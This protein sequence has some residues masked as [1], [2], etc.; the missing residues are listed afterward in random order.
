VCGA[1][2]LFRRQ[3]HLPQ[4]PGITQLQQGYRYTLRGY[5]TGSLGNK[6]VGLVWAAKKPSNA[7]HDPPS[8]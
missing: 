4:L 7:R 8:T 3:L 6:D 2:S 5:P 1:D